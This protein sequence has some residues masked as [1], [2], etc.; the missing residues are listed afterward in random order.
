MAG[1]GLAAE[2]AVQ[3]LEAAVVARC[4]RRLAT[5]ALDLA[6]AAHLTRLGRAQARVADAGAGA[7][8][9]SSAGAAAAAAPGGGV[10]REI[11]HG[12]L[13]P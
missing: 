10:A 11:R 4:G 12:W 5:V 13:G 6:L 3:A 1:A 8:A 7:A 2:D 9:G